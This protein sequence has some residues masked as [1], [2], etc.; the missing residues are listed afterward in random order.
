[1][2]C[3]F[4]EDV[5]DE[6]ALILRRAFRHERIFRDRSEPLA[7]GD[8]YL[9]ERYRFSGCWVQKYS[10]RRCKAMLS[11]YHR[12]SIHSA[13][14]SSPSLATEDIKEEFYKFAVG[15]SLSLVS[16]IAHTRIKRPSGEHEGDYVNRKSFHS[17]NIQMICDADCLV[18]NLEAKW[19]GSVHDSRVFR[20]SPIYEHIL[21]CAAGR[22]RI[23]LRVI[24]LDS[25]CGPPN[26][27]TAG[28]QPCTQQNKGSYGDDLRPS[29]IS[30]SVPAPPEGFPGSGL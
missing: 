24:P 12:W 30:V 16:W 11:L 21:W 23:R 3:P 1:M 2:A 13:T 26:P 28:L 5:L 10:T 27:I 29:E 25:P 20:A 17:I 18:S 22:Q 7:F 4:L 9:I 19:P 6:E 15:Y 14:Y 8:D